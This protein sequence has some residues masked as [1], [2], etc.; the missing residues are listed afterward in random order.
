MTPRILVADD[1]VT[2]QKVVE[3]TFSKEDFQIIRALNGAEAI[4]KAKESKPDII[5]LDVF[6][7]EK[8]GYEVC[9]SL[10]EDPQLK[11]VPII[12]LVA[13]FEV[14]DQE[15]GR[16][17]GADDYVTKPFESKQ[18]IAKVKQH[19]FASSAK[20]ALGREKGKEEV[21]QVGAVSPTAEAPA[22][23]TAMEAP[24]PAP[25][26]VK[27]MPPAPEPVS[28]QA[29]VEREGERPVWDSE[30][31]ILIPAEPGKGAEAAVPVTGE[32]ET[33]VSDEELWQMLDLSSG[34][35]ASLAPPP[36]PGEPELAVVAEDSAEA[37][38]DL[39]SQEM[40]LEVP[41]VPF[42]EP[43]PEP[44]LQVQA[45]ESAAEPTFEEEVTL[46]GRD[47]A[48]EEVISFDN[49]TEAVVEEEVSV[50]PAV[51]GLS[52]EESL[53]LF[54][55]EGVS[56]VGEGIEPS[57][58]PEAPAKE[59]APPERLTEEI[60]ERIVKEVTDRLISRIE[61]IIWEVVPDLAEVLITKE[62]EKIKAAAEEQETS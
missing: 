21:P 13:A 40:S 3:L 61:R 34:Q 46:E 49:L 5:L 9:E 31:E 59:E 57:K 42:P 54:L 48:E 62:I 50:L 18:L 29:P 44:S 11:E 17:A 41:P 1:S 14:F 15:R 53:P 25:P 28:K 55:T 20:L 37:F 22:R 45:L 4:A 52:K 7:P 56:A 58:K 43:A 2:I 26:P 8:N 51:E 27:E 60:A 23:P 35:A 10:R 36:A 47:L 24:S 30:A 32:G 19:L 12:L 38:F 16:R 6:M 33:G 39:Y